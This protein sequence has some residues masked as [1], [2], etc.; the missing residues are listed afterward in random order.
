V[1]EPRRAGACAAL[2]VEAVVGARARTDCFF[3]C[4]ERVIDRDS[5]QNNHGIGSNLLGGTPKFNLLTQAGKG[6][7]DPPLD[8]SPGTSPSNQK[9]SKSANQ[10]KAAAC[11]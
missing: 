5:A 7:M 2:V 6:R 1:Q 9:E 4:R 8:L 10:K 11:F 3:V